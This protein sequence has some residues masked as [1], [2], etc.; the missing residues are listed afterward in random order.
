LITRFLPTSFQQDKWGCF[1]GCDFAPYGNFQYL[2]PDDESCRLEN[3]LSG[4][5]C[6][7]DFAADGT[8]PSPPK[9]GQ[10]ALADFITYKDAIVKMQYAADNRKKTGQPFFLVTGIKRP[11]I[12]W[13]APISYFD[14]YP[15]DTVAAPTQLTLDNSIDPIAYSVFPMVGGCR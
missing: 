3:P 4:N 11:H 13:R 1:H 10:T 7:P 14:K 15:I 2:L 5:Y 12:N 8:P 6:S 9:K